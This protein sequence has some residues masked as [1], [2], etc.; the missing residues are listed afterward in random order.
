[1]SDDDDGDEEWEEDL[2]MY[3]EL[4]EECCQ[5]GPQLWWYRLRLPR[6]MS[7]AGQGFI[8]ALAAVTGAP[9]LVSHQT[10]LTNPPLMPESGWEPT[11][12]G[13]RIWWPNQWRLCVSDTTDLH[14]LLAAEAATPGPFLAVCAAAG[15]HGVRSDDYR[16]VM[17]KNGNPQKRARI[18][19]PKNS[20]ERPWLPVVEL[21]DVRALARWAVH[22]MTHGRT[23]HQPVP[24]PDLDHTDIVE[25]IRRG[26]PQH[27]SRPEVRE[28]ILRGAA[29]VC[30]AFGWTKG[31]TKPPYPINPRPHPWIGW[32][33]PH[34]RPPVTFCG[35]TVRIDLIG[36]LD[37]GRS[38]HWLGPRR[39]HAS[40]LRLINDARARLAG[41]S[42]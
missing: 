12:G 24:E 25:W 27:C 15:Y 3:T 18:N 19:T 29:C 37:G 36:V 26:L 9:G 40:V 13:W 41:I 23:P 1:M 7:G 20:G 31:C 42:A 39:P 5:E 35:N 16:A 6:P 10:L 17:E 2:L 34:T 8:N 4:W 11:V 33:P 38:I 32:R 30:E 28:A 22:E 14:G 21:F